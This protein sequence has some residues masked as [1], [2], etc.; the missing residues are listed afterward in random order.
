MDKAYPADHAVAEFATKLSAISSSFAEQIE[1]SITLGELLEIISAVIPVDIGTSVKFKVKIK[2]KRYEETSR[3]RVG[4]LNDSV[5]VGASEAVS[6]VLNWGR[7]VQQSATLGDLTSYLTLAL[8]ASEIDFADVRPE[9]I[10]VSAVSPKPVTKAKIG[11]IVAIPA[12]SGG[13]RTALV[14]AKNRFGMALGF[15][16]GVSRIPIIQARQSNVVGRPAYTDEQ[17]ISVGVWLIVGHD[18][19]LL[20]F[21]SREPEIYHA[22]ELWPNREYGEF[23]AAET[24]HG[25]IRPIDQEEADAVGLRDGSYRQV[26]MS[27]YLQRLLDGGFNG[28]G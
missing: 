10:Q 1:S 22:P 19:D 11:N 27:E 15:F 2:G 17:L 20:E 4:E 13:Y 23:G 6:E 9:A 26:Y 8:N 3:S 25:E 7:E 12:R 21:F 28:V 24:A 18:E 16:R 5:F 14:L